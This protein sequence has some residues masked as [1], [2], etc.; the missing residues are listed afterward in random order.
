MAKKMGVPEV[1]ALLELFSKYG[2]P[3]ILDAVDKLHQAGTPDP[4]VD[5]IKA[6]MEGVE[7]PPENP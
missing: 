7:P 4:T 1:L 6:I 2:L 5:E 3:A